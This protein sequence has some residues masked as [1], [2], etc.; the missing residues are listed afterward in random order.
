MKRLFPVL[1]LFSVIVHFSSCEKDDICVEGDT[2]LLVI[3]FYDIADTTFKR[4]PNLRIRALDND[5]ILGLESAAEFGFSDR[6]TSPD[7][8]FLPLQI[9]AQATQFQFISGS[10]ADADDATL[11]TGSI[12]TLSFNYVVDEQFVSRACGFVANF[13][14]LDTLRNVFADDWIKGINIVDS[15]VTNSNL[16]HVQIF[17]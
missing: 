7:S 6:A 8:I 4:V 16:I 15:T 1:L 12:D 13:N 3:G 14:Q 11:E 5:S 2:P 9:N 17:H 10:A